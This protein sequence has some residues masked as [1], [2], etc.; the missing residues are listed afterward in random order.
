M[1]RT[2][3]IQLVENFVSNLSLLFKLQNATLPGG[4]GRPDEPSRPS[5]PLGPEPPARPGKPGFPY[6]PLLPGK[7]SIQPQSSQHSRTRWTVRNVDKS[8]QCMTHDW[9]GKELDLPTCGTVMHNA[10]TLFINRPL[11][12]TNYFGMLC[13]CFS[14][15]SV[16]LSVCLC[17]VFVCSFHYFISFSLWTH[18]V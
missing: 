8:L 17:F 3:D 15:L 16:C 9:N 11:T 2:Y 10:N 6:I 13:M 14:L 5:L 7:P 1:I 18:V 4:P 12:T